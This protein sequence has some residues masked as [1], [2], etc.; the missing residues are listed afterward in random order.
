MSA[1]SILFVP[2][3]PI[4]GVIEMFSLQFISVVGQK[5]PAE[6]YCEMDVRILF[7]Y[8][9][10]SIGTLSEMYCYLFLFFGCTFLVLY[11]TTITKSKA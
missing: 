10:S 9:W 5:T 6:K 4:L 1:C 8:I 3:C 7:I 11:H 2:I